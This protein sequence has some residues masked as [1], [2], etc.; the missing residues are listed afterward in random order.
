MPS[1]LLFEYGGDRRFHRERL[2]SLIDSSN[3]IVRIATAYITDRTILTRA[4]CERRLLIPLRPIDVVSGATSLETIRALI[5]D[6]VECRLLP[7]YPRFHAK[8]Y[9]FGV[10]AAIVTSA[11]LTT[12]ALKFNVEVGSELEG[13]AVSQIVSWFDDLWKIADLITVNALSDIAA[14]VNGLRSDYEKL[15]KKANTELPVVSVADDAYPLNS[16]LGRAFQNAGR[17]FLCNTNR[18]YTERTPTVGYATEEAMHTRRFAAAWED[19]NYDSHMQ[20]VKKDDVI[21]MFAK[22]VGVIAVGIARGTCETLAVGEPTRVFNGHRK[23]EWRVPT[24]WVVWVDD[25]AA[26]PYK[27]SNYTFANISAD[28]YSDLRD[29]VLKHFKSNVIAG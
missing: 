20:E 6:G 12:S 4:E 10:T 8:T 7:E 22:S 2:E 29:D 11:N 21:L 25:L 19:F 23:P 13:E 18:R 16:S 5:D 27:S 17:F 9:I 26:M 1:Q 15:R 3:G 14:K 24:E 28:S